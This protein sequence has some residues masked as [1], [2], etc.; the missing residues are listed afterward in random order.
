MPDEQ[1]YETHLLSIDEALSHISGGEQ[2]VLLYAWELYC[3][4]LTELER[5]RSEAE[6]KET[7]N[8][9]IDIWMMYLTLDQGQPESQEGPSCSR[10]L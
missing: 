10:S 5:Q 1:N 8:L 4:T 9:S 3:I 6:Q 7:G 2:K